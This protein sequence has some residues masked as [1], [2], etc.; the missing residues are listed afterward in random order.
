ML[1][2][3]VCLFACLRACKCTLSSHLPWTPAFTFRRLCGRVHTSAGGLVTQ[4]D[5][6][7]RS[8]SVPPCLPCFLCREGLA[9]H[10]HTHTIHA[11][12]HT[13]ETKQQRDPGMYMIGKELHS[14]NP[15]HHVLVRH[16]VRSG[17]L[18]PAGGDG[19]RHRAL[20]HTDT[21]VVVYRLLAVRVPADLG[22]GG[23]GGA[24]KA[25]VTLTC[26][27][28]PLGSTQQLDGTALPPGQ[29]G[30]GTASPMTHG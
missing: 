30:D 14:T 24:R 21:D 7:S 11:Y 3:C 15:A 25:R 26:W 27:L 6:F 2:L 13:Y 17:D 8:T 1:T 29:T 16:Q 23:G 12:M 18:V 22:G 9:T 4:E 10:T 5:R 19:A 20:L 28:L